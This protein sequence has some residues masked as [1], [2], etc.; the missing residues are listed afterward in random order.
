M[1]SDEAD[2]YEKRAEAALEMAQKAKNKAAVQAHYEM[3]NAYL[4]RVHGDQ[5]VE[6]AANDD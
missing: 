4:D 1:K 5:P 6:A 2:Y 3:A